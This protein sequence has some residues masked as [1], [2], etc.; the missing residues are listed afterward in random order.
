[1]MALREIP[2]GR[3]V[4]VSEFKVPGLFKPLCGLSLTPTCGENVVGAVDMLSV[5]DEHSSKAGGHE[6]TRT[7]EL[8]ALAS[9]SHSWTSMNVFLVLTRRT[10]SGSSRSKNELRHRKISARPEYPIST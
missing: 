4:S 9:V 6:F 10:I 7:L 1:M 5:S 3:F 8:G 2:S